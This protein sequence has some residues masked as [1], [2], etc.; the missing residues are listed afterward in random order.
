ML[1]AFERAKKRSYLLNERARYEH[2]NR[3]R[4]WKI[5]KTIADVAM[6]V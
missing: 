5:M 1:E 3:E 2:M 4:R 6:Y